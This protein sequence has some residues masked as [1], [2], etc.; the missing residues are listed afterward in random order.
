LKR[1]RETD[2]KKQQEFEQEVQNGLRPSVRLWLKAT[3]VARLVCF[4]LV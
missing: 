1:L 3:S 2:Q 4:G